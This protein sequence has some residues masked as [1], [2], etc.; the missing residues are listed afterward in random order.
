[1]AEYHSLTPAELV[2]AYLHYQETGELPKHQP[3]TI[4]EWITNSNNASTESRA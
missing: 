4:G 3:E 1:M 2:Q